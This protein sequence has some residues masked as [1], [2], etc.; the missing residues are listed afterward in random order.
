[1]SEEHLLAPSIVDVQSL[2]LVLQV[3]LV[4]CLVERSVGLFLELE[5]RHVSVQ[6]LHFE[7]SVIP[8]QERVVPFHG[9]ED[10]N[11]DLRG[12]KW[13]INLLTKFSY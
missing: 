10:G 11:A 7:T 6:L 13:F 2:A 4:D 3:D 5:Q 8:Y 12:N 1:M 9:I